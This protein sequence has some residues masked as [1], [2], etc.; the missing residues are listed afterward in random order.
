VP[1][2]YGPNTVVSACRPDKSTP[3]GA[4]FRNAERH[5]LFYVQQG[6]G[7]LES[8]YGVLPFRPNLYLAVPKGTTYRIVLEGGPAWLL[9][10]ESVMPIGFP[11]HYMNAAGQ[12]KMMAP[13]VETEIELPEF[14]APRDEKGEF[15]VDVQHNGGRISRLVLSHHP[16]DLTGWEGALYPY[17]FPILSHHGIAR[18]IHTAPPMHETFETGNPPYSGFSVCSFVPQMEGWHPKDVPA[19]YAHYNVDSDEVMFFSNT[20]YGA[21]KGFIREGALTFHPGAL[22][23]SPQGRAAE[24]S[25]GERS[26]M[27]N[28]LAVMLDTFFESLQP[29]AA[30]WELR[31]A[32]YPLSWHKASDGSDKPAEPAYGT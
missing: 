31:D 4:F 1:L 14:A 9:I 22:P 28:R 21:R 25:L 26:K 12:A 32:G 15:F 29:T 2:V 7:R 18:A 16:F 23:H 20:S 13:V 19:P 10:V 11:P 3:E 30:A 17:A 5:E 24:R 8:E 27:S 6:K